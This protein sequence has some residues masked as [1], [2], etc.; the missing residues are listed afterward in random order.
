MRVTTSVRSARGL[1]VAGVIV[2][3]TLGPG[4]GAAAARTPAKAAKPLK[5]PTTL[6][7][8]NA[9]IDAAA[10]AKGSVVFT[11]ETLVA[12]TASS[13]QTGV[14]RWSK[15]TTSFDLR[16]RSGTITG[17]TIVAPAGWFLQFDPGN[18]TRPG[19]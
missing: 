16:T 19:P 12:G 7:V 8:L 10:R 6:A 15:G 3:L 18:G 17:R 13:S 1:I 2:L 11:H 4:V 14:V 9:R 5:A